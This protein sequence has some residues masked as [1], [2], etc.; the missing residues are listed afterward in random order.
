MPRYGYHA[1]HE[2]FAPADLLRWVQRAESAGLTA[3][4]CSDHLFPWLPSH[5][6]G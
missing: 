5:R 4:M 1:S 6:D 3:D 2:Q